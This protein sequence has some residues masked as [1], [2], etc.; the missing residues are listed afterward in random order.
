MSM[1]GWDIICMPRN[2]G[3]LGFKKLDVMNH[4]LL[5]KLTWEVVS[6]SDKLWVKVF[7]S[8]YGLD[9]GNLPLSLPDKQGSRIWMTIRKTWADTMHGA[10]WSVCDGVRTWF[11]LDCWVTKQEPLIN[12]ALQ[13][14]SHEIINAIVSEFLNE[15]GG[16]NWLRFEHLLPNYILMQIASVMPPASQLGIDKICWSFDPR[17]VFTVRSTYDS[18]CRQN[19]AIQ[20]EAWSLAWSWKGPQSIHLFLWQIMHG[21]LKTHGELSRCHIP[22]SMAC[23]RCGASIEDILYALRDCHCIKQV[24]LRLVPEGDY[25]SLFHVNLRDWIVANLQNKLKFVSHIPWECVFGVAVWRLWLWRNH[26]MVEGKLV[27]SSAIN[28]DIMARANEIHRVNNSHMS[29]QPRRKEMLIGWQ[30]PPW[31]WY[32]LNTDGSV[33]NSWDAGAGG[34]I[35]DSVGHWIFE[36]LYEYWGV[37]GGYG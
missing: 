31:P 9:P 5:M 35:R 12:F 36:I 32:K 4:A 11:W 17:G 8:K 25:H 16:W 13:P 7:C 29:Q 10:R 15:H 14:I 18:I 23:D 37:F 24:W 26:F 1:V 33:R 19:L 6:N 21:K 27:D 3:G 28:M 2:H 20:D 30:P 22:V 34:V